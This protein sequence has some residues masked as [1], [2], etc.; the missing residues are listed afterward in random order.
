MS[1][2][3]QEEL[4]GVPLVVPE[5]V[6]S[7]LSCRSDKKMQLYRATAT[8]QSLQLSILWYLRSDKIH[9][10]VYSILLHIIVDLVL[11]MVACVSEYGTRNHYFQ[12]DLNLVR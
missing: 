6:V 1:I 3:I 11:L 9:S 12:H 10:G 5:F 2:I 4:N 7:L 8:S